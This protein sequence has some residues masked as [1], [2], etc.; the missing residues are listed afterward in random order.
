MIARVIALI[1][2]GKV[3][4]VTQ[5]ELLELCDAVEAA[6]SVS[7][8]AHRPVVDG[9]GDAALRAALDRATREQVAA[10]KDRDRFIERI[11]ELA[12]RLSRVRAAA[13]RP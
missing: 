10:E 4:R 1:R 2:A 7:P 13:W 3:S 12:E 11:F 9:P 6:P 8:E 5:T